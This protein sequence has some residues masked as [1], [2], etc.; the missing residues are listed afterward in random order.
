MGGFSIM[1]LA[2]CKYTAYCCRGDRLNAGG[3]ATL[4]ME[5]RGH[6]GRATS[7]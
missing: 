2:F 5:V 3:L 4:E 6:G 1:G 7:A